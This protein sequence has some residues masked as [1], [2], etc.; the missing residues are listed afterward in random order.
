M[1]AIQAEGYLRPVNNKH[2]GSFQTKIVWESPKSLKRSDAIP[3][4]PLNIIP[5]AHGIRDYVLRISQAYNCQVCAPAVLLL[6]GLCGL[7]GS[8][9]GVRPYRE[10]NK[11]FYPNT[12][13]GI[14][15]PSGYMK[16]AIMQAALAPLLKVEEH[17]STCRKEDSAKRRID[18]EILEKKVKDALKTGAADEN[19]YKLREELDEL[20]SNRGQY[21]VISDVTVEALGELMVSNAGGLTLFR[22]E[23]SGLILSMEKENQKGARQ[24]FLE[25]WEGGNPYSVH[26]IGR[27]D[28]IIPSCTLSLIGGFQPDVIGAIVSSSV[29]AGSAKNDGFIQRFQM[30]VCPEVLPYKAVDVSTSLPDELIALFMGLEL[31][32]PCK[33]DSSG[34]FHPLIYGAHDQAYQYW[35]EWSEKWMA[36]V[37]D[38]TPALRSHFSKYLSLM[39]SLGLVFALI[40]GRAEVELIDMQR[41]AHWCNYLKLHARKMYRCTKSGE[42]PAQALGNKILE[43]VV[44]N[45]SSLKSLKDR[46]I[47]GRSTRQDIDQAISDLI[48]AN[49]INVVEAGKGSKIIHINPAV[50]ELEVVS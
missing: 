10:Q 26:R 3:D 23:M 6:Q 5:E 29:K 11:V 35:M 16:S 49:W 2:A 36:K 28:I 12:W 43:G 37:A 21:R 7:I 46:N 20:K 44:D 32:L 1:S 14:V 45:G 24:F 18:I 9:A 19:T 17:V 4:I 47:L 48:A 42:S 15:A 13:G 22:D 38:E 8:R 31:N 30:M 41:A 50:H 33:P 27:G 39:A 40:H 25:S 34:C